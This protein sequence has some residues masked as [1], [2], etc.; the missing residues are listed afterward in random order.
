[1]KVDAQ[2]SHLLLTA[3]RRL[4][5]AGAADLRLESLSGSDEAGNEARAALP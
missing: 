5:C 2:H 3:R 1:M 4:A